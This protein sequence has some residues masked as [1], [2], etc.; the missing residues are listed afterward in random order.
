ML[1]IK[2]IRE[3]L[4]IVKMAATK[5]H[6]KVDL[7][8]LIELDD[9]RKTVT[10][11]LEEKKAQQNSVSKDIASADETTRGQLIAEMTVLKDEIQKDEEALKPIMEE[12]RELMLQ[13]PQVPD[14]T[15]PDGESD[16]DNVEVK[17]WTPEGGDGSDP[18]TFN[19]EPKHC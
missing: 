7:D 10:G 12:W 5:K 17:R 15:V 4:E 8:R 6:M 13:V 3:N 1:D 11:T 14:M 19:F 18:Q 16:E 2:F 9:K